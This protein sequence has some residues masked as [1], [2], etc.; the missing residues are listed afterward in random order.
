MGDW[1]YVIGAYT[2]TTVGLA[3][4]VLYLLRRRRES[5]LQDKE[6]ES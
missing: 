2:L 3:L 4:Y 5:E 1:S 6:H